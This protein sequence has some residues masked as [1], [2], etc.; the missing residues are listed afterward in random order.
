MAGERRV[1]LLRQ[2]SQGPMKKRILEERQGLAPPMARAM[3]SHFDSL[4]Q[5]DMPFIQKQFQIT[6]PAVQFTAI[7]EWLAANVNKGRCV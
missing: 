4:H 5:E 1:D 2:F 6:R 7:L 3:R